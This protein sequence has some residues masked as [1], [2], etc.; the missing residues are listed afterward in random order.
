MKPLLTVIMVLSI[1]WSACKKEGSP[2]SKVNDIIDTSAQVKLK[3]ILMDGPYG[4]A[5]G[6]IKIY[7][8]NGLYTLA[9][10]DFLVSNGPDLHVYLSKEMP[11]INFIDLGKIKSTNGNQVYPIS[12]TPDFTLYKFALIHCQQFNHLFGT[13]D[14]KLTATQ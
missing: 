11:P 12:G 4:T 7:F 6:E 9:L 13:S 1:F 10:E 5:Q 2:V 3:G 8:K 14:L